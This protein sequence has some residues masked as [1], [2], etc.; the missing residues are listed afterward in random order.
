[1]DI[2]LKIV[3]RYFSTILADGWREKA[4]FWDYLLDVNTPASKY[5]EKYQY[6]QNAL[7]S[8]IVDNPANVILAIENHKGRDKIL[9]IAVH[10]LNR[11]NLT[12]S[13]ID[14]EPDIMS[15]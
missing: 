3:N 6:D 4:E 12:D 1:M 9:R 2:D 13:K 11:Q 14:Q 8:L 10:Q 7:L 5:F 15:F